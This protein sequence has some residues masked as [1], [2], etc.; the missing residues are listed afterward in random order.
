MPSSEEE[1]RAPSD[2]NRTAAYRFIAPPGLAGWPAGL[3]PARIW[4]GL[5]RSGL[6]RLFSFFFPLINPFTAY[7]LCFYSF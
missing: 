7:V 4:L 1:S 2:L 6:P 3:D 5:A